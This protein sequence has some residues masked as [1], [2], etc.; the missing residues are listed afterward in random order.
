MNLSSR[1]PKHHNLAGEHPLTDTGQLIL[2]IV[3]ITF[4]ILDIFVFKFSSNIIG[5]LSWTDTL[6]LFL[7]FFI[8]G[9]YFIFTSHNIIFKKTDQENGIITKG[10]FNKVRHPM[11]FGSV[12]LF[13]SFVILSYSILSFCIWIVICF[14]YYF[15]SRYEEK[16]LINKFG[17]KYKEYQ[18]KYLCLCLSSSP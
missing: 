10:V 15:V 16:L 2:F 14:F 3:F 1:S 6:P 9:I 11:Y 17:D 13:F 12:L 5:T 8:T 4:L 18:K 7:L